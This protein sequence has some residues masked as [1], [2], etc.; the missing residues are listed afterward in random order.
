[1]GILKCG[2]RMHN[3]KVWNTFHGGDFRVALHQFT[4]LWLTSVL[5]LNSKSRAVIL[6]LSRC[7]TVGAGEADNCPFSVTG[8]H[9]E[10]NCTEEALLNYSQG[11]SFHLNPMQMVVSR[12][13]R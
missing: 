6:C 3:Y 7:G 5:F 2:H 1:M 9:M 12:I 8:A 4:A 10:G 11:A 13:S